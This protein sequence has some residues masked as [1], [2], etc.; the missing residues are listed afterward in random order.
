MDDG[1]CELC[2]VDGTFR[3]TPSLWTQTFII[4]AQVT[5]KVFVPVVFALL[6]DK[7]RESYDAMFSSLR[8]N[9]DARG[10]ELSA[11]YLMSG[12]SNQ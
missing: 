6:P 3:I 9:L 1:G 10:L 5:S 2:G 11:R 8:D 7:K 12:N 4:S